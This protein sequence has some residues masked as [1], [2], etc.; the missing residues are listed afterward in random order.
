MTLTTSLV[1]WRMPFPMILSGD[2]QSVNDMPMYRM[3]QTRHVLLPPST[4]ALSSNVT[5]G[6]ISILMRIY[7]QSLTFNV[8]KTNGSSLWWELLTL[9]PDSSECL[10]QPMYPTGSVASTSS[11]LAPPYLV[12]SVHF[13]LCRLT[14]SCSSRSRRWTPSLRPDSITALSFWPWS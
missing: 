4:I 8:L 10:W 1:G 14:T 7:S 9:L 2:T 5:T 12:S 6:S 13:V 3:A 11:Y